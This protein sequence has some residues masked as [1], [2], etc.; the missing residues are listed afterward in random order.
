M[1]APLDPARGTAHWN[2]KLT[3]E[4]VT[5]IRR[6]AMTDRRNSNRVL[7]ERFEVSPALIGLVVTGKI[8][9]HVPMPIVDPADVVVAGASVRVA[10]KE[11]TPEMVEPCRDRFWQM[12]DRS[13]PD[14]CW[15]WTGRLSSM[16]KGFFSI[17]KHPNLLA[18]RVAW[19]LTNNASPGEQNVINLCSEPRCVNPAHLMLGTLAESTANRIDKG[20]VVLKKEVEPKLHRPIKPL[21][22]KEAWKRAPA[23][24]LYVDRSAGPSACWPWVGATGGS[25]PGAKC[26]IFGVRPNGL[27]QASRIAYALHHGVDPGQLFV[28]HTCDNRMCVN[29][30]HLFLGT[31]KDNMDDMRAKGRA[32]PG[33]PQRGEASHKAK[34]TEE[35]VRTIRDEY[36]RRLATQRELA[37]RFALS[38]R[39]IWMIVARRSWAHVV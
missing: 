9:A 2:S 32:K 16:K 30:A 20:R 7:A 11:I 19:V 38:T 36:G 13:N 27:H 39:Q 29:P 10:I 15:L 25:N 34:I 1:P 37:A 3:E 4:K 6:L 22:I 23:F 12:A 5:E 35:I 28:C 21:N 26:G 33:T 24:F 31:P 8:W 14:G 17:S 18:Q